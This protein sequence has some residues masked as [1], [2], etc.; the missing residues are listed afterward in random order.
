AQCA[1]IVDAH[2]PAIAGNVTCPDRSQ[3]AVDTVF[4]HPL[5]PETYFARKVARRN[6]QRQQG[7]GPAISARTW[8][9]C[10]FQRLKTLSTA[11]FALEEALISPLDQK[12]AK[13]GM[14]HRKTGLCPPWVKS[15]H[16]Q[17]K[18]PCPLSAQYRPSMRI[19]AKGHVC[20]RPANRKS[21]V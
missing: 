15:R 11:C 5:P 2:Q 17:C 12:R 13:R 6:R 7:S 9:R 4:R 1:F 19:P 8:L 3:S 20:F 14:L 10:V 18:S 16:M 21:C